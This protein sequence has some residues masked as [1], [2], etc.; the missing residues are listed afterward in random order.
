MLGL[1][2]LAVV[3]APA[4]AEGL[5]APPGQGTALSAGVE[6]TAASL[7]HW[8]GMSVSH[9]PALQPAAW[10]GVENVQFSAW[11]N[12]NLSEEDGRGLSE[13]DLVV[14]FS[15]EWG[16]LGFVPAVVLYVLPG[17]QNTAEVTGDFSWSPGVVGL[18]SNHALDFWDAR[19]AWWSES[20]V[21]LDVP[22]PAGLA[23]EG[24]L[25]LGVTNSQFQAY[26]LNLDRA[27]PLYLGGG[28]GLGWAHD[29][30]LAVAI[31]G[32]LDSLLAEDAREAG[33]EE[34]VHGFGTLTVS[35]DGSTLWVK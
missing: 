31:E 10:I 13:L 22:L 34:R 33:H 32:H 25:G 8:R 30:G 28:L 18:Y 24:E 35:W 14:S 19:P 15:Q 26:Y 12:L 23:V 9:G 5:P 4:V 11:S 7:Y 3:A 27:G 1:A 16:D 17:T 6:L 2:L 20:G 21:V 29:S